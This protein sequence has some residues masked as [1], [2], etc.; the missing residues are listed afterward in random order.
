MATAMEIL[1]NVLLDGLGKAMSSNLELQKKQHEL[2]KTLIRRVDDLDARLNMPDS[3]HAESKA[4]NGNGWKTVGQRLVDAHEE[5]EDGLKRNR[6]FIFQLGSLFPPQ[7]EGKTVV[8]S[9]DLGFSTPG[10]IG[11]TRI[12]NDV[13]TQPHR[14][15][16]IA[17]LLPHVKVE[18]GQVDE[19]YENSF[20]SLASPVVENTT[21][22]ESTFSLGVRSARV[23]TIAHFCNVSR[24]A[25]SDVSQLKKYC[26][27]SMIFQLLLKLEAEILTGD[28]LGVHL[29]GLCSQA[30]ATSTTFDS[31]ADTKIDKL[32]KRFITD[33]EVSNEQCTAFVIN[34]I[35]FGLIETIK[36]DASGAN[37][38]QY[39]IGD[40]ISGGLLRVPTLWGR[41][42]CVTNSIPSGKCLA[43]DFTRCTLAL[44]SDAT[45][46]WSSEHASNWTSNLLSGLAEV[47]A[48]LLVHRVGAFRFGSI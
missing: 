23:T 43:G 1:D 2:Q 33:L 8:T 40:P 3:Y 21:K 24:Q 16:T 5:M 11:A 22:P 25:M 13:V 6:R 19:I 31:A 26:D 4:G 12:L 10:V 28:G 38:G 9:G 45:I 42:V 47:R 20:T 32:R 39:L 41:P 36:T 15:L 37:T 46:D 18:T 48:A 34:P 17:D 35:D 29:F 27:Q 7:A 30:T 44:R 14:R